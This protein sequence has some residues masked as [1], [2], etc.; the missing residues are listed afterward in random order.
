MT[1]D[2]FDLIVLAVL[3]IDLGV[4]Y[5]NGRRHRERELELARAKGKNSLTVEVGCD[6]TQALA[7]IA[8]IEAAAQKCVDTLAQMRQPEKLKVPTLG[9]A[10]EIV[11]VD[12]N[13][14]PVIEPTDTH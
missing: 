5:V 9:V 6:N 8:E 1:H 3:A 13:G 7:A 12:E 2:S 14:H 10:G 4:H 11:L